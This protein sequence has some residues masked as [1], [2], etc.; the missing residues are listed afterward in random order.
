[1][2]ALSAARPNMTSECATQRQLCAAPS[3]EF[4]VRGALASIITAITAYSGLPQFRIKF[5][6]IDYAEKKHFGLLKVARAT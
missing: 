3:V 4:D 2:R 6:I 1:M 5:V